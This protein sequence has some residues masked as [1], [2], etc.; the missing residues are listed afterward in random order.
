MKKFK[1][2]YIA[3][4]KHEWYHEKDEA[5]VEAENEEEAKKIVRSWG[6]YDWDCY[7]DKVEEL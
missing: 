6:G 3:H 2:Y 5:I 4:S 7:V 1:V